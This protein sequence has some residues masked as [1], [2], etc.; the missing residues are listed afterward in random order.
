M[1]TQLTMVLGAMMAMALVTGC[2]DGDD[3]GSTVGMRSSSLEGD[4][5]NVQGLDDPGRASATSSDW[6]TTFHVN[7]NRRNDSA[8]AI[9]DLSNIGSDDFE[10]LAGHRLIMRGQGL[11]VENEDGTIDEELTD[12]FGDSYIS[13]TG[14]SGASEGNWDFDV[15]TEDVVVE[16]SEDPEVEGGIV[17]SF[18]AEFDADNDFFGAET[19]QVATGSVVFDPEVVGSYGNGNEGER[20]GFF[21]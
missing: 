18:I 3:Y 10:S 1:R 4:M 11:E 14:C 15:P 20:V 5:G 21:R 8:M 16:I 13:V 9:V 6:G 19:D 2:T 12:E 17:L 7:V